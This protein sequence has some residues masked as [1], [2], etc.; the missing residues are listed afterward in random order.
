MR[1][2]EGLDTTFGLLVE[3][4]LFR[5]TGW[6]LVFIYLRFRIMWITRYS[7]M[8]AAFSSPLFLFAYV[9]VQL[10]KLIHCTH[11]F[12]PFLLLTLYI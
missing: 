12:V 5:L 2:H 4:S 3:A 11:M 9:T 1:Y 10:D 7:F 8:L 6:S